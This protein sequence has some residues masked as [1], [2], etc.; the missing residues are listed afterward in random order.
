MQ[1]LCLL[2][3][4]YPYGECCTSSIDQMQGGPAVDNREEGKQHRQ[5]PQLTG[6]ATRR[7]GAPSRRTQPAS[8]AEFP[9]TGPR[10]SRSR[11]CASPLPVASSRALK[12]LISPNAMIDRTT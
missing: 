2:K 9:R 10:S 1:V 6:A 4:L 3:E 12:M 5:P 11:A 7:S 8:T